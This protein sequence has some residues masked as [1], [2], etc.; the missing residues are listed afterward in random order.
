M[1]RSYEERKPDEFLTVFCGQLLFRD[2][3]HSRV[4]AQMKQKSS[5]AAH[6]TTVFF[7]KGHILLRLREGFRVFAT[8]FKDSQVTRLNVLRK[9]V[10]LHRTFYF[11]QGFIP[12]AEAR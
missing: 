1:V 9:W 10:D 7:I 5:D 6:P 8:T 2:F 12:S 3:D 11:D 4:L